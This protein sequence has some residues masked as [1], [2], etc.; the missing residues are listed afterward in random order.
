LISSFSVGAAD[1]EAAFSSDWAFA[2]AEDC[3]EVYKLSSIAIINAAVD[4]DFFLFMSVSS[5]NGYLTPQPPLSIIV[6]KSGDMRVFSV[7][8]ELLRMPPGLPQLASTK[9][10]RRESRGE[11]TPL[12]GATSANLQL[13]HRNSGLFNVLNLTPIVQDASFAA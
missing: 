11:E 13:T 12:N 3:A 10:V 7:Q 6:G 9:D 8:D 4:K 2:G 5:R 1:C